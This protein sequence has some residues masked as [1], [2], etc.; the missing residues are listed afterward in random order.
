MELYALGAAID[1]VS[2]IYFDGHDALFPG[3]AAGLESL[4]SFIETLVEIYN[5]DVA[6]RL[7]E[8]DRLLGKPSQACQ[9][10]PL[11]IDLGDMD[12]ETRRVVARTSLARWP[13]ETPA[14]AP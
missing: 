8:L 2:Q 3:S 9:E 13:L 6:S 4:V 7:D 5:Q 14:W 10:P 1:R 12:G 11:T